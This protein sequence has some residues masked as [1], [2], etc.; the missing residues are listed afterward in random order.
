MQ[1]ELYEPADYSRHHDIADKY[2]RRAML[3][4]AMRLE[5]Q[6]NEYLHQGYKY[7]DLIIK[8]SPDG[9]KVV[10]KPKPAKKSLRDKILFWRSR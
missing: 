8:Q 3:D 2:V 10:L 9:E 5:V 7:K 6:I 4:R 1:Y